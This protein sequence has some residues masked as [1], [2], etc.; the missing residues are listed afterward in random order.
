MDKK[1]NL[2]LLLGISGLTAVAAMGWEHYRNHYNLDN[3]LSFAEKS[4]IFWQRMVY[5]QK[6]KFFIRLKAHNWNELLQNQSRW[7][8][9][10][11]YKPLRKSWDHKAEAKV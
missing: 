7:L 1:N 6:I 5:D 8:S 10:N 11:A 9:N 2:K 3:H 4:I